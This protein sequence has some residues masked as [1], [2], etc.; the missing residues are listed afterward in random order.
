MPQ[1]F[2][3]IIGGTGGALA[4]F[5]L[6]KY[7]LSVVVASCLIGLLGAALEH[8]FKVHHLAF[9]IFAGSFVGMSSSSVATLPLILIGGALS[10]ILY[11]LSTDIFK[12]FGG[13]LGT[14]AFISTVISFY[15]LL[16]LKKL[17]LKG[18]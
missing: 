11:Q 14:I 3:L 1:T 7:G 8:F 15:F 10:G 5:L 6:H 16:A 9:V 18:K 2:I 12:G 13:R 4:T 17:L